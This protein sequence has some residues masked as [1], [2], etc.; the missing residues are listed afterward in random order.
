MYPERAVNDPQQDGPR[1]SRAERVAADVEEEILSARLPVGAHLGRR[2]EFMERFGI[3]PTIMNETLRILRDRGMVKVRPGTNGGIFVASLPPQVRL[4]AMDLWFHESGTGA[5]PL[6]LF[7]ARVHLEARL[8]E[9]AFERATDADVAEMRGALQAMRRAEDAYA[10]LDGVMTLHRVLVVAARVPVLDGM[11]Q[12]VIAILRGTLTRAAFTDGHEE[13]L[14]HSIEVHD[15]LVDAIAHRDRLAFN[16]IMRLH[17]DDLI[18][19]GDPR[20][21]PGAHGEHFLV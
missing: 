8:T 13:M 6:D 10:Y 9:V 15:G 1:R 5:H 19:A 16:K 3:S 7:E 17:E 14:R 18:R 11:H 2:A 21:S 12:T 4:G 20:R